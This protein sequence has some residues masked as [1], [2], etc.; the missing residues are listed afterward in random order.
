MEQSVRARLDGYKDR[1]RRLEGD[2]GRKNQ[3]REVVA[4]SLRQAK[5]EN[6]KLKEELEKAKHQNATLLDYYNSS[7]GKMN[8]LRQELD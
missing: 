4:E 6:K 7:E 2:L 8:S 1:L 5:A 3:E